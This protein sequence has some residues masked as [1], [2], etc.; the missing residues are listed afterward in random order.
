MKFDR[1]G[2]RNVA[3]LSFCACAAV[4]AF[5]IFG[6]RINL[7][8][9]HVPIGVW[10]SRPARDIGVGDVVGYDIREFYS[11]S[12]DKRE[13]RMRFLAPVLIKR[14]AALPGALVT[15]SGDAVLIDGVLYPNA[16]IEDDS[17]RKIDYPLTVPEGTVW[18][19]ADARFSYDSRYHGPIPVSL[20]RE[21]LAPVWLWK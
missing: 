18:I 15:L 17:W 19:M 9:S 4:A 3:L 1:K 16:R 5:P 2:L 8:S 11:L 10:R 21:K 7:S 20:L 13:G 12:P 6:L 14:V